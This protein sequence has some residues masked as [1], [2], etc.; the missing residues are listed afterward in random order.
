LEKEKTILTAYPM[1]K[2]A[3][4]FLFLIL[5]ALQDLAPIIL[6]IAFFQLVVLQQPI[7]NLDGILVGLVLVLLGLIFFI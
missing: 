5:G 6:V 2:G 4:A 7:L 1:T 3:K